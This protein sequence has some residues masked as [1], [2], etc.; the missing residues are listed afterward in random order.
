MKLERAIIATLTYSDHF[1]FP[2]TAD[3][4]HLRLINYRHNSLKSLIATLK[5]MVKEGMIEK[6]GEYFHLPSK[7]ALV[8]KRKSKL[9]ASLSELSKARTVAEKIGKIPGVNAVYLTGSLAMANSSKSS[10]IDLM[11]ITRNNTLWATRLI[12]TLY[13]ELLG[14][15]RRPNSDHI[16]GQICLN[17]YLSPSSF[18]L[19]EEKRSLYTA[20]ELI[21]AIPLY[22]PKDT[23]SELISANNWIY[24]FLPNYIFPTKTT[25]VHD[26]NSDINI[27]WKT[28]N[29]IAYHLQRFNMRSKI[30]REYITKDAA[31]F[32]PN[33]PGVKVLKKIK[34][35]RTN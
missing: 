22:D 24:K 7:S 29:T 28:L 20:Y 26:L 4:I 31:F 11:I 27:V 2:L 3:E 9:K 8:A 15:R 32:H 17:L 12:L 33:D 21:Q 18:S 16:E 23:H 1:S 10:D 35:N 5:E 19:P 34:F 14:K 30:T 25:L 13:L 6:T